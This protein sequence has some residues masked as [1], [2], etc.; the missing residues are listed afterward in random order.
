M[1]KGAMADDRMPIIIRRRIRI[2]TVTGTF[3]GA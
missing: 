2:E 1:A 3:C